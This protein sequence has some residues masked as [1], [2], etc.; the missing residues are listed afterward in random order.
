MRNAIPIAAMA[1]MASV[2]FGTGAAAENAAVPAT[3]LLAVGKP[4]PRDPAAQQ[5]RAIDAAERI[6]EAAKEG[7]PAI[8]IDALVESIMTMEEFR[9]GQ[10]VPQIT[11]GD[12]D[13]ESQVGED[14]PSCG[15]HVT[16]VAQADRELALF[17]RREYRNLV[18]RADIGVEVAGRKNCDVF[19]HFPIPN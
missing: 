14:Q 17:I 12:A 13:H 18:G 15:G 19:G 16:V 10:A 4:A 7:Q 9:Q 2:V 11:A 8:V 3:R 6:V 5:Q 1:V